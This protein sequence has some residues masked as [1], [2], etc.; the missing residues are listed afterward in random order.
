MAR[1]EIF[2]S[3]TAQI[4]DALRQ[5]RLPWRRPWS[6]PGEAPLALPVN[7]Q[8]Q[9]PYGGVN[10]CLLWLANQS[11]PFWATERVWGN[12]GGCV[13]VDEMP[14]TIYFA[15]YT[16]HEPR[17][18]FLKEYKV[19]NQDQVDGCAWLCPSHNGSAS[20]DGVFAAL[21]PQVVQGDAAFYDVRTDLI[22]LPAAHLFESS[23]GYDTTRLHELSHWTGHPRRLKRTFA[24]K[25]SPAYAREELVAE[26][27]TCFLMAALAVPEALAEMPNHA[28][29]LGAWL[30]LLEGDE[31]VFFAAAQDAQKAVTYVLRKAGYK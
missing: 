5:G 4:L 19:Y 1:A 20:V 18:P 7:A 12:L 3:V 15:G 27:A 11:S 31:T 8:T 26:L 10:V 21:S 17:R 14:T 9:K 25:N 28:N 29:Y 22:T 23:A 24:E 16:R 6:L 30:A 2:A 13:R